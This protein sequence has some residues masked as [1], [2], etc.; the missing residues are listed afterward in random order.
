MFDKNI[1]RFSKGRHLH[2]LLVDGRWQALT[3]ITTVLGIIA[4]PFLIQWSANEAVDYIDKALNEQLESQP[5]ETDLLLW[6]H[7]HWK[8]ITKEAK[9]AHRKKKEKAGEQG[10]DIHAIIEKIIKEAIEKNDGV[11][12]NVLHEV[13]QVQRFLE[14]VVNNNV[15]FI[16]S[17]L[18]LYSREHFLGGV[19]DGVVEIDGEKWIMDTKTGGVYAEAFFQM[20]G[21]QL[22]IEELGLYQDIKGHIILGLLKTGEFV[23]KRSISNEDNKKAFLSALSLYRIKNKVD[24]NLI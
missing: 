15:R 3:G 8:E 10:T 16:A 12:K 21:Y 11:I 18:H 4:K 9:I 23:E 2:E 22:M 19:V 20:A 7:D 6:L 14:W 1:Y 5:I 17:E 24:G 13:P